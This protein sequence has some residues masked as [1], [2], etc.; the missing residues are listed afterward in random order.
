MTVLLKFTFC[1]ILLSYMYIT[2]SSFT[3][4]VKHTSL[5]RIVNKP[6]RCVLE[7]YT[8]MYCHILLLVLGNRDLQ[9]QRSS[10]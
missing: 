6:L 7:K 1:F 8:I 2:L 3:M 9:T 10:I 4:K 5:V